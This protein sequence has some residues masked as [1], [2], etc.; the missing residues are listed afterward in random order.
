MSY[1]RNNPTADQS[2]GQTQP[3]FYVNGNTIDDAIKQDH[4]AMG[5]LGQ[6]KH[7]WV[8]YVNAIPTIPSTGANETIIYK[9]SS[10]NNLIT[11]RIAAGTGTDDYKTLYG[12]LS[13]PDY[14]SMG[15]GTSGA[16]YN[17]WTMLP[18]KPRPLILNY[19]VVFNP[20][21]TGLITLAKSF[22][23]FTIEPIFNVSL[24]KTSASST[25]TVSNVFPGSFRYNISSSGS[26]IALY[27]QVIGN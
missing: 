20:G 24:N 25:V 8:T 26:V 16:T 15:T 22:N 17:S 21:A 1:F 2:L 7:N 18:G 11:V 5:T 19:G 6:G 9:D 27:Y 10:A 23:A 13:A 14:A 12:S 3:T 4:V